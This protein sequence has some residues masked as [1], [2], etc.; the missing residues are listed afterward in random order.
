MSSSNYYN[1]L[2]GVEVIPDFAKEQ[3]GFQMIEALINQRLDLALD[4]RNIQT[5]E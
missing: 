4:K 3:R 1:A 2:C 5:Y